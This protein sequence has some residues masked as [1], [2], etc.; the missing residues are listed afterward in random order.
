MAEEISTFPKRARR[1][2]LNWLI[3]KR[4]RVLARVAQSGPR[5]FE[6]IIG[7]RRRFIQ[8]D[9]D[10]ADPETYDFAAFLLAAYA[11]P[12]GI[13]IKFDQAVT[14][15]AALAVARL[16]TILT[17]RAPH[18][19]SPL[20]I[21]F[22]QIVPDAQKGTGRLLCLSGGVDSAHL[23]ATEPGITKALVIQGFDFNNKPGSGFALRRKSVEAIAAHFDLP[24]TQI[25]SDFLLS[26]RY[27][28]VY[29]IL[30]L[31]ACLHLAGRGMA[32]GV[33]SADHPRAR[34]LMTLHYGMAAGIDAHLSTQGFRITMAGD[35]LCRAEKIKA[36]HRIAPE[37]LQHIRFCNRPDAYGN[38]CGRCWKCMDTRFTMDQAGVP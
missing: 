1:A 6:L 23:A 35:D 26:A 15:S 21:E 10:A 37:V 5:R 11:M 18:L 16:S 9:H 20:D 36:L 2:A 38:N 25:S 27:F 22:A 19:A 12:R 4:P 3:T 13:P 24:L 14:Q 32:D 34:Q 17:T 33:F 7:N 28:E 8:M 31:A 29:N 30:F